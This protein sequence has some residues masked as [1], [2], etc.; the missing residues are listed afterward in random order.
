[1][2]VGLWP[3]YQIAH[4]LVQAIP[5]EQPNPATQVT[6]R[7]LYQLFQETYRALEPIFPRLA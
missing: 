6:Y 3:S 7:R 2:G 1:V 5:A 4:E